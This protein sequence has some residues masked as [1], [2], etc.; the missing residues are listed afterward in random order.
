MQTQKMKSANLKGKLSKT[1]MKNIIA[2]SGNTCSGSCNYNGTAGMCKVC[3]E[4]WCNG[5]CY[6]SNGMGS[7]S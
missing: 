3:T 7:C 2:G 6:C 5:R 4:S 1:E